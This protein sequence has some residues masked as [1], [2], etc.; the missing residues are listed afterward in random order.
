MARRSNIRRRGKSWVV[1]FRA[2][3]EQFWKS[4]KTRD[5]AELYLSRA[6]EK[7]ARGQALER[8]VKVTFRTAAEHW[9]T[10]GENERAW[11]ASTRRDYRSALDAHLLPAFGDLPLEKLSAARI[12]DWRSAAM[13]EGLPRRTAEKLLAILHG[14]FARARA[15]PV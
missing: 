13:R 6:M 12:A 11:K 4:F 10:H 7:R 8:P 14:I 9:Y 15:V 1:H 3:G 2:N 5:E